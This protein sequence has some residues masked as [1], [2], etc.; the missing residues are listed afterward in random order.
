METVLGGGCID[1]AIY[2]CPKCCQ[3]MLKKF[4]SFCNVSTNRLTK[5][6]VAPSC[7]S[8]LNDPKECRHKHFTA[9]I[10]KKIPYCGFWLSKTY[11]PFREVETIPGKTKDKWVISDEDRRM[12]AFSE[13]LQRAVQG[14]GCGVAKRGA[15]DD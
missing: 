10:E 11:N 1:T 15:A 12:C 4:H 7:E 5:A 8:C 9:T 13:I 6:T 2:I 14:D 3:Y